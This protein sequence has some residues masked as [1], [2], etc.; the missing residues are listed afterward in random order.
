MTILLLTAMFAKNP[1][2]QCCPNLSDVK[3]PPPKSDIQVSAKRPQN[4]ALIL[5]K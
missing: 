4:L 2:R 1:K 5:R 3:P